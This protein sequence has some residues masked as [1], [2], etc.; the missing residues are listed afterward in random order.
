MHAADGPALLVEDASQ[1]LTFDSPRHALP[2]TGLPGE[3]LLGAIPDGA[4]GV[5]GGVVTFVGERRFVPERF[6]AAGVERLSAGGGVVMPGLVDSHTHL[7]FAGSRE[8]EFAMRC[9]GVSYEE[10]ARRGGGIRVTTAATREATE[11]DLATLAR[12]R[13]DRMLSLGVTTVEIKSGYGLSTEH[14]LKMLRAVRR[15]A[16]EV[17]QTLVPTFL[18]AHTVPA[19]YADRRDAY[20]DLVVDEML[21]EVA[22]QELARFCDV[23]CE[24]TA[25]SVPQA[26]RVL[27]R[28]LELGLELKV[29]AEQLHRTGATELA[30][31]LGARSAD[32]LEE[33]SD[34]DIDLLAGGDTVATLLPGA[35]LFLG[36]TRWPPARRL[37]DAGAKVALAT[38]CNPGSS[39]TE[40][41]L[42]MA[43]LGCV[44]M[45]MSTAEA[46]AAVT[47]RGAQALG[48]EESH[49]RLAPGMRADVVI[50]AVPTHEHLC[51]HF[52]VNHVSTVVAGGRVVWRASESGA[53]ESTTA[54]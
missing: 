5:E 32:H 37:L 50:A 22:Y 38:D 51:Y 52:G 19:E 43:T 28:A 14:E 9:G 33:L 35:T 46:L 7:V 34:A 12:R 45:G 13:L 1:V 24:T 4:V 10:I 40:N 30:V 47:V 31:G 20:V 23:F 8:R 48:L 53:R 18:G 36:Q 16:S 39:M 6:R 41:L 44:R 11:E 49:G 21:P 29:H 3:A 54:L 17:P 26:R 25:F 15:L 42:L 27:E 2:A